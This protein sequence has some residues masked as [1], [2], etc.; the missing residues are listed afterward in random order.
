MATN[1][2][3]ENLT[4]QYLLNEN[5]TFIPHNKVTRSRR[6]ENRVELANDEM[7][8]PNN[9]WEATGTRHGCWGLGGSHWIRD[10]DPCSHGSGILINFRSM[11][12]VSLLSPLRWFQE[13][14]KE[15]QGQSVCHEYFRGSSQANPLSLWPNRGF[16]F[17][18]YLFSSCS[19]F[20][21]WLFWCSMSIIYSW[22]LNNCELCM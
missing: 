13:M 11:P 20:C 2:W 4:T 3:S 18:S 10:E 17:L 8:S 14:L 6:W 21:Y 5:D 22:L 12:L 16:L 7:H 15:R 9:Y 1:L 19:F